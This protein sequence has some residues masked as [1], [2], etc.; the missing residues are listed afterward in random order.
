MLTC[1]GDTTAALRLQGSLL[2]H[3]RKAGGAAEADAWQE[4]ALTFL[5]ARQPED[6]KECIIKAKG[7]DPT[8]A[9]A[10]LAAARFHQVLPALWPERSAAKTKR[11]TAHGYQLRS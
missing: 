9:D 2:G 7:L 6:A 11:V 1:A 4:S 10:H 8:S 5:A 3:A